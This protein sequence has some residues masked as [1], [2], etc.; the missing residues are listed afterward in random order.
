MVEDW[1]GRTLTAGK[2]LSRNRPLTSFLRSCAGAGP[3][4]ASSGRMSESRATK[5][6]RM[7]TNSGDLIGDPA[8]KSLPQAPRIGGAR[9]VRIIFVSPRRSIHKRDIL[10][11]GV[12]PK[13]H[14]TWG[15]QAVRRSPLFFAPRNEW[16]ASRLYCPHTRERSRA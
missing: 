12:A 3:A 1:P 2:S 5:R 7:A 10:F 14:T 8:V 4:S 6:H 9:G 13:G 16:R 15:A 11:Q